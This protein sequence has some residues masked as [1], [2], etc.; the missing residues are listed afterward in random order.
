[1]RQQHTMARSRVPQL[2]GTVCLKLFWPK[3]EV[4]QL[5]SSYRA[6]ARSSHG[7]LP[8]PGLPCQ[9]PS[10]AISESILTPAK[11]HG[12]APTIACSVAVLAEKLF[13][14]LQCS[15]PPISQLSQFFFLPGNLCLVSVQSPG[16]SAI[17]ALSYG[18]ESRRVAGGDSRRSS[19][20]MRVSWCELHANSGRL[21]LNRDILCWL[22]ASISVSSSYKGSDITKCRFSK[23]YPTNDSWLAMTCRQSRRAAYDGC[24][25]FNECYC[26]QYAAESAVRIM[27]TLFIDSRKLEPAIHTRAASR[28][29]I[30]TLLCRT[31]KTPNQSLHALHGPGP[32]PPRH[33]NMGPA[34]SPTTRLMMSFLLFKYFHVSLP[35][36]LKPFRDL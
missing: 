18:N 4:S 14:E 12:M 24:I 28:T 6:S 11:S 19:N 20:T 34:T 10:G 25:R 5:S 2:I 33:K 23:P 31:E 22:R 8:S 27:P 32:P 21:Y 35:T 9:V 17:S 13:S 7:A 26:V 36:R 29:L 1:M 30:E 15:T 16:K 3:L